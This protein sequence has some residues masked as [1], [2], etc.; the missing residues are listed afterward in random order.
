L[1]EPERR[2]AV[3]VLKGFVENAYFLRAEKLMVCSGPDP[4][5]ADRERAKRQ[6]VKSLDE[7][8]EWTHRLKTDYLLELIL[9]NFDRQ[10]QKKRLLGP[11]RES[12]ELIVEVKKD[13]GN[14]NLILDQSHLRQLDED[15]QASL[16]L[17][18]NCLGHVHLANCLLKDRAHPQWGDSHLAFNTKGGELGTDDIVAMFHALFQV[19]YLTGRG[20]NRLPTISLEVKPTPPGSDP[21][22]TFKAT[23]NT[24]LE[25][26]KIFRLHRGI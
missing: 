1:D 2:K 23:C 3:E 18:R 22:A 15:H 24:F 7:L 21:F 17:A 9:E 5:P 20:S 6:L 12:V 16:L 10:L 4:G 8:L 25:A 11:T 19:G 13:F 14:I 26:W